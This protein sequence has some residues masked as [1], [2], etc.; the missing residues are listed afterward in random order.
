M[1]FNKRK[2]KRLARLG[3]RSAHIDDTRLFGVDVVA[4]EAGNRKQRRAATA[5]AKRRKG[6]SDE[7]DSDSG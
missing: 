3:Q 6:K 7:H 1:A 4:D 5:R 2:I